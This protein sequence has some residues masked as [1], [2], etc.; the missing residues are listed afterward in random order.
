MPVSPENCTLIISTYNWPGALEL[1]LKSIYKQSKMPAEVIIA[2]DGSTW[3]TKKLI[4]SYKDA[5]PTDLIHIW[6][7]DQGFRLASIRNKAFAASTKEYIIQID[8]DVFLHPK[9]IEDHLRFAKKDCLLQGSRVMLGKSRSLELLS[10]K[11]IRVSFLDRDIKRRENMIRVPDLSEFLLNRY[12]NRYPVY[13]ARGANMSFWKEDLIKV[14]GY[15][16]NFEGWGHEDSD[17]TLRLLNSGKKKFVLKF[18]A[19]VY[20][21]DH[22]ENKSKDKENKNKAILEKTLRSKTTWIKDGISK[23]LN[24]YDQS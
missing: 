18:S 19:I 16:E 2:D 21:L 17:L 14:N 24:Q 20:H 23:H 3:E 8:G 9:F 11:K 22:Q 4:D 13:F 5:F 15:N 7:E 6:H 12:R 10:N 1:T